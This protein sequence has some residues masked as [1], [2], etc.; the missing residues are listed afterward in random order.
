MSVE[1]I[2]QGRM[3]K[4]ASISG[5]WGKVVEG[6]QRWREEMMTKARIEKEEDN[7]REE[8]MNQGVRPV[9]CKERRLR[10]DNG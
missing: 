2:L 3:V 9:D 1:R 7:E 4:E 10:R 6:C 8:R 5:N